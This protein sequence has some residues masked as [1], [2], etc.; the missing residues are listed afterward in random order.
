MESK[1]I[2]FSLALLLTG[3]SESEVTS[4]VD[5]TVSTE[6]VAS[7]KNSQK[8]EMEPMSEAM[9]YAK[10]TN[11]AVVDI[12]NE[13]DDIFDSTADV[14]FDNG[15][16][17][18]F[19]YACMTALMEDYEELKE[20]VDEL[21]MEKLEGDLTHL[22]N[23]KKNSHLAIQSRKAYGQAII[24]GLS[25]ETGLRKKDVEHAMDTLEMSNRYSIKS[26]EDINLYEEE[27]GF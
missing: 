6:A 18:E 19:I 9:Y 14:L 12:W 25:G 21:P 24:S 1:L 26:M 8:A 4:K 2:V 15:Y 22:E 20:K 16:D 13:F 7:D 17:K 27:K 23:F 11:P 3:C 10:Y 5:S